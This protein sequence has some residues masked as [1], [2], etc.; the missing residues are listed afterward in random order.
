MTTHISKAPA[1]W[2]REAI[3]PG[4]VAI[5]PMLPG[6]LAFGMAFGAMCAQKN[7]T[8]AEVEVMMA[9]V[10]GGLSQFVAVQSWPETL[11]PST[12]A[13]LAL[14][15]TTVNIR[16][17]LMT[18]SMRPWFGTLPAWQS[19][20]A[21]LLVTDGGWLAAMRYR[22]HGGANA[23]F[24]VAGGL[25]LYFVW[26]ISSVPG[27]L[28]AEQL[29]DPKKY[30]VDLAMPAFFAAML[31]PAWKGAR[32]AIPWAVSGAVALTVHWLTPGYWFIIA[33]ALAGALSAGL[34]DEPPPRT[35]PA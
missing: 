24:Y 3:W 7:F 28:L 34:M 5:G 1:Y 26:L 10:Y 33:G 20:P 9:T 12:I 23:A 32:R 16:F 19:Y 14:L 8:L 29:S 6:T 11:T 2:S 22:E 17:F 4:I 18:A 15:T 31:V 30:G 35:L 25:V 13:A 27:F 21:M